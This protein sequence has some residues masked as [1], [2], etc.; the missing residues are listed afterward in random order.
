MQMLA[1]IYF[2]DSILSARETAWVALSAEQQRHTENA[3]HM[4]LRLVNEQRN[5][6]TWLFV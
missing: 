6:D 1:R 2:R 4:L 3:I 5:G